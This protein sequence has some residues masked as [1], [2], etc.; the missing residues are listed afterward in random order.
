MDKIQ[1]QEFK[2]KGL[3]ISSEERDELAKF[4]LKWCPRCKTVKNISE[5]AVSRNTKDGIN[6][7]CKKC[8]TIY[9]NKNR[10]KLNV[11]A[12]E[13]Y[14]ENR[15]EKLKQASDYRKENSEKVKASKTRYYLEHKEEIAV[16]N[17]EYREKNLEKIKEQQKE[18]S[19]KRR[20]HRRELNKIWRTNN[21]EHSRNYV[22]NK[23]N[24]DLNFRLRSICRQFVRRAYLSIG[25]KKERNTKKFL[26]YTPL[27]LKE[28][29]EKQ[30]KEGMTWDNYGEW[31]IDHIIPISS[32]KNLEEGIK[33]SQLENLQP[34]WAEENLEKRNKI[35]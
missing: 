12:K 2:P 34:L 8:V 31:H 11:R 14:Q 10:E 22:R 18:Y 20:I 23:Y 24:E 19:K 17:R 32:A 29:I 7:T 26:G 28:H 27:E 25:T 15:E 3:R 4:N 35:I 1:I 6:G 5:F 13:Y 9:A 16:K 33:L 30:F 21:L